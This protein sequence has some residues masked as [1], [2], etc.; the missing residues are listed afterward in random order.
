MSDKK[1]QTTKPEQSCTTTFP[2]KNTLEHRNVYCFVP[3]CTDQS[4]R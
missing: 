1:K 2:D 4:W 3:Q